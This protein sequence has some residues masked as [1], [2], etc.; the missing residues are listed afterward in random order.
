MAKQ[1]KIWTMD[2]DYSIPEFYSKVKVVVD[3]T[4]ASLRACLEEKQALE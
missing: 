3:E 4:Y 2:A 1:V